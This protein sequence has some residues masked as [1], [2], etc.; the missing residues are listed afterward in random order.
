VHTG[1]LRIFPQE[2]QRTVLRLATSTRLIVPNRIIIS[3][4]TIATT[5]NS[6]AGASACTAIT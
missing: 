2:G 5:G 6:C 3:P 4:A 1:P